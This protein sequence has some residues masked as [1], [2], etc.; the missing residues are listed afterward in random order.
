MKVCLGFLHPFPVERG[1]LADSSP[2]TAYSEKLFVH[3]FSVHHRK[4]PDKPLYHIGKKIRQIF[5]ILIMENL[6][7]L[8]PYLF[9]LLLIF[10]ILHIRYLFPFLMEI[11]QLR[12]RH[13]RV[14]P[15]HYP[16]A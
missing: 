13:M 2:H 15:V 10:G 8:I 3:R 4:L 6:L 16:G 12:D 5:R 1:H 7:H 14:D 9:K 11:H